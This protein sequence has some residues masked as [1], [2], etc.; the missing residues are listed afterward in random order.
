MRL[1]DCPEVNREK[2]LSKIKEASLINAQI[3][4]QTIIVIYEKL[5]II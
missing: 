1:I 2:P 5:G 3:V 4:I